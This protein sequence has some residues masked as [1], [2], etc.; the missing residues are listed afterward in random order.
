MLGSCS[1]DSPKGEPH[2][3]KLYFAL[4]TEEGGDFFAAN[5]NYDIT[6]VISTGVRIDTIR[7]LNN[8]NL[9]ELPP[10][11]FDA[12]IDFSNSDIDTLKVVWEPADLGRL[13]SNEEIK[14]A[15]FYYNN[16]IIETWD[17]EN[18]SELLFDLSKR[19]VPDSDTWSNDPI[20]IKIVKIN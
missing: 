15:T 18:N 11:S 9:F 16:K 4:V 3:I 20:T 12:K 1:D 7:L 14:K 2:Q 8:L 10:L 6:K 5:S 17:F 13:K 19:N